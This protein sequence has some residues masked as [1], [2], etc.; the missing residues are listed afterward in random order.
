MDASRRAAH[1]DALTPPPT[2]T[3]RSPLARFAGTRRCLKVVALACFA[4]V[5]SSPPMIYEVSASTPR[6]FSPTSPFN[7]PIKTNPAID[8]SSAAMVSYAARSGQLH[9]NLFEFAIPIYASTPATPRYR[10]TCAKEGEWGSC[11]L[12][13]GTRAIPDNARPNTGDDG[14]MTVMDGSAKTVD[15]YWQAWHSGSSWGTTWGAVNSTAGSGWGG[16]STGSGASRIAG[17]VRVSEIQAG[18]IDHALVLQSDNVCASVVRPPAIKTDGTSRRSDCIPEGARLQ[19]DPAVNLGSL[20]GLKP[21]ERTVARALQTYGA[22]LI[23][24]GGAPLSASF[25]LAPDATSSSPGSVYSSAGL[26]WDY[27]GM[28]NVPWSRLRVL[29]TWNG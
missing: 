8:R 26:S 22:Y 7:V 21:G 29:Q 6:P 28:P 3:A 20:S 27:Y 11:P 9:A 10:V 13:R 24:R 17:V 12:S 16:S 25:E 14:V 18:V 1:P 23:D 5:L 15:E 2:L 4:L 19:L